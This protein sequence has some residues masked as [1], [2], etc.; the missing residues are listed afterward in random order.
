MNTTLFSETEIQAEV[1]RLEATGLALASPE[2]DL[3]AVAQLTLRINRLKAAKNAV[4]AGHVYQ[5]AEILAG[6]S[7]FTGDSY[8]L[9]KLCAASQAGT[10]VFCGV[11]FMAETA[12]ILSPDKTVLLPAP[13][14]GCT[15]ADSI[16]AGDVRGLRARHPG[17]PVITYINTAVE[18]KAE[19]DCIV[20][21]AN[22]ETILRHYFRQHKRVIFLPDAFMG[23]NL[24]AALGKKPGED[25]ILWRGSCSV[26]EH[27]SAAALRQ[28]RGQNEGVRILVHS[29]CPPEILREADFSGGTS[30]MMEYIERNPAPSYMLVTE[31]GLGE[32]AKMKFPDKNFIAMC[33]LCPYM[34]L[35]DLRRI[36]AALETAG[37]ELEIPPPPEETARKARRALEMMF[38][39]AG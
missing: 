11:K 9:A 22:A 34:K 33:R 19:S 28:L 31:C 7:D 16:T 2:A 6:V 38:K 27:F 20:T 1:A 8:R 36:L 24:A 26:H 29:E 12:K 13:E 3:R 4:I 5:R 32:L 15:L 37:P 17:L 18:V 10:I 39:L 21:S 14:A 25:I 30:G 23:A 35:T